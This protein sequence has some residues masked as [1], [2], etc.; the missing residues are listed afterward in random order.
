M[1]HG[2]TTALCLDT[3]HLLVGGVDPLALALEASDR[4]AH[5]HL[6]DVDADLAER[7]QIR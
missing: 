5:V 1:L 7:V 6:K 3:G 2:S 4:V